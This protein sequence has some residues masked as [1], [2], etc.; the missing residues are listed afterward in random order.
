MGESH[1]IIQ[2]IYTEI[3]EHGELL[4]KMKPYTM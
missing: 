1:K 2:Q 3:W 4:K